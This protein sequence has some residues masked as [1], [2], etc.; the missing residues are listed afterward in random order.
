MTFATPRPQ[1]PA[2]VLE[3]AMQAAHGWSFAV[4]VLAQG[5]GYIACT[6]TAQNT[7]ICPG[8]IQV[9]TQNGPCEFEVHWYPSMN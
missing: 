9:L 6:D 5:E 4:L 8:C 2:E 1:P 3:M 7:R